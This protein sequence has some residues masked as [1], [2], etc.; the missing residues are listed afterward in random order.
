MGEQWFY[1][2]HEGLCQVFKYT[3]VGGN[4]NN[5]ATKQECMESC[6]PEVSPSPLFRG[7]SSQSLVRE[8]YLMAEQA[9][10]DCQVSGW[11]E[12][13]SC[14]ASCG[15]GWMTKERHISKEIDQEEEMQGFDAMC[16]QSFTVVSRKLEDD[17]R[18]MQLYTNTYIK[19]NHIN[20]GHKTA[21]Q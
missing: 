16:S 8:D 2:H 17:A 6:H 11:T 12:W 7:L 10:N 14:S 15:R 4:K 19:G 13:S 18:I 3:G 20:N 5:F 21:L 1:N 9:A